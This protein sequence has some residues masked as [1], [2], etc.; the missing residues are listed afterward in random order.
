MMRADVRALVAGLLLVIPVLISWVLVRRVGH[1][2]TD[3]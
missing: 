2:R 3:P 1:P